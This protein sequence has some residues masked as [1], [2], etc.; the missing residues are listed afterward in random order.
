MVTRR[1]FLAAGLGTAAGAAAM[2]ACGSSPSTSTGT[3]AAS[4]PPAGSD[5]GAVEHVVFLMQENRSFDHYFGTYPAVRGF[6]DR[7]TEAMRA[8]HQPWPSGAQGATTLLPYNLSSATAQICAG[9]AAIPIHDWAP[10]HQ[11]W[12]SGTNARFVEVHS[13]PANDG[14]AN[15]PLV[16]GYFTRAQLAYYYALADSYTICDAYHSSVIGPTMPNRLYSYSAFID[17]AGAHGGPVLET[18]GFSDAK[19]AVASVQWDTMPE[20]LSD[21]GISWK[22]YQPPGTSAGP[23]Q[24]SALALGF[25]CLLYF[26]QYLS[27]PA[28]DLYRRAFLPSWPDEFTADVTA[29]KLPQVSWIIPPLAYS[30]HPSGSPAAGQWFVDQVVSAITSN[31]ELWSKTVIFL[32]Y[33]EN[34]GFFDHVV[35][36]TPP[37]GTPGEEVSSSAAQKEGGGVAGPIGLG[38]RVPM[39][40]ISPWSRGGWVDSTRFDHTSMLRFLESRF[41]VPVPNL[42]PWRRSVVGDLTSTLGFGS[43]G[44]AAGGLPATSNAVGPGCPTPT[45]LLPFID[46][47]ETVNVPTPGRQQLPSQEPGTRK[48]R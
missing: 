28:S 48:R 3:T 30:E 45:N 16:M 20:V 36:P 18:P 1:Q 2:A 43:T 38:F 42:T 33:D 34:G 15:A 37:A 12:D 11:S 25:N 13:Q 6:D 7:S 39:I 40:V 19:A 10:Q 23:G 26:K 44:P 46:P 22:V 5:L 17:P 41:G 14:P 35:P 4:V 31:A 21:H 27:N 47:P 9:N 32:M 29:G 24:D 8:F